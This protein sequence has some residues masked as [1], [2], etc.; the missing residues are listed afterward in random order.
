MPIRSDTAAPHG[1]AMAA[2][3]VPSELAGA[4]LANGCLL[5][6]EDCCGSTD[7]APPMGVNSI[8]EK[9]RAASNSSP[10]SLSWSR[11]LEYAKRCYQATVNGYVEKSEAGYTKVQTDLVFMRRSGHL[12][13]DWLADNT[14]WQ[15]KPRTFD[16]I[17][18]ALE[19]TAQLYR[20]SLWADAECYVEVWLEKDARSCP[21]MWCGILV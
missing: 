5:I 17:A 4:Y 11:S 13:Y 3:R 12:P 16:G 10:K 19:Q 20:K 6:R 21:S 7:V 14:R 18:S 9:E 1:A 8:R 2:M 15:R